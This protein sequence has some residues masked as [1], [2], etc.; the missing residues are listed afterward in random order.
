MAIS[1]AG[2]SGCLGGFLNGTLA[3]GEAPLM[4]AHLD[5]CPSCWKTWNAFR[6][7]RASRTSLYRDLRAFLGPRFRHGFDSS[8]ALARE[9]DK[10]APATPGDT[11]DFFRASTSY[12]YNLAIWEASGNRP[13]YVDEAVPLL[14]ALGAR[15]I[16]DYGSGIGS[17][18]L[19]LRRLGFEVTPCDYH[20]PSTRFFQWRAR[21]TG[22]DPSVCE[23]ERLP[24]GADADTLWII[25]T[26]DHLP[27]PLASIGTL[28]ASVSTIICEQLAADRGHGRQGFHY[29]RPA[30][31]TAAMLTGYGFRPTASNRTLQCWHKQG[32]EQPA[33][34]PGLDEGDEASTG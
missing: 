11:A 31:E 14:N 32:T 8:R 3:A 30:S 27:D 2:L 25:D 7:E 10:A 24:T 5:T 18:T 21:R 33:G 22:Q 28:L 9:W 12:L 13:P 1:C 23:P 15:S 16:I 6:W 19:A 34:R 29:R 26:L 20:S 17:D 4:R